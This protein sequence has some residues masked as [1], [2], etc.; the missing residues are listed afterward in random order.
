MD[1]SIKEPLCV[2]TMESCSAF[3]E[4]EILSLAMNLEDIMLSEINQMQKE[5]YMISHACQL[6]KLSNTWEQNRLV[7]AKA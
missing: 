7:L 5:K 3:T 6:Q 4:K 2:C 1:E